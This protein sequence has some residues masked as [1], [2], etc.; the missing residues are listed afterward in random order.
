VIYRIQ[1]RTSRE[2]LGTLSAL[3]ERARRRASRTSG[4]RT[5]GKKRRTA[6]A[7]RL[8][9]ASRQVFAIGRGLPPSGPA[10]WSRAWARPEFLGRPYVSV[11]SSGLREGRDAGQTTAGTSVRAAAKA[12]HDDWRRLPAARGE[13]RS[14]FGTRRHDARHVYSPASSDSASSSANDSMSNTSDVLVATMTQVSDSG[15]KIAM[16]P[17]PKSPPPASA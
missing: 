16:P 17:R 6:A 4:R 2:A 5:S 14:N 13:Y 10:K 7:P 3:I 8:L 11:V 9:R 15:A 1:A 12:D